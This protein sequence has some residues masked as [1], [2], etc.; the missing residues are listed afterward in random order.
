MYR[1]AFRFLITPVLALSVLRA[2]LKL[3]YIDT[4]TGFY[5][6]GK[7]LPII[8]TIVSV[9]TVIG[10]AVL[11]KREK[12][13][14]MSS[15]R[16]NS[17]L[18]I[19]GIALG[20]V[21]VAVNGFHLVKLLSEPFVLLEVNVM[22]RPMRLVC[23]AAGVVSGGLLAW[24][25]STSLSG[26]R[27]NQFAGYASLLISAWHSVYMISRFI[28]FRQSATVSDQFI[29]TVYM[30]FATFFWL[31]HAKC[32]AGVNMNRKT[33]I[34]SASGAVVL[35]LPLI[36]G[37]FFASV[38]LGPVSGPAFTE[39]LLIG[40]SCVYFAVFALASIFSPTI[41]EDEE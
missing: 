3:L 11:I 4:V 37:Q 6:G 8:Y 27:R 15:F 29:E 32:I 5:S 20:I 7:L 31:A 33:L 19:A 18:E 36:I 34:I 14:G 22:P 35:G 17:L 24:I 10:I 16:G 21:L 30:L 41:S 2:S 1:N 38:V 25:A 28:T 40:A 12:D 13:P 9:F 26:V 23:Y 39:L